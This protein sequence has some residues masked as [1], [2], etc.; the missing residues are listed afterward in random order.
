M[1]K[2]AFEQLPA[3]IAS[4]LEGIQNGRVLVTRGGEP[5]AVVASVGNKDEEDLELEESPEFWRMIRERRRE[6]ATVPLRDLVAELERDEQQGADGS[7]G[8]KSAVAR[9]ADHGAANG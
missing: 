1:K 2:I 5:F 6:T 7:S 4:V 8:D 9:E 3:E